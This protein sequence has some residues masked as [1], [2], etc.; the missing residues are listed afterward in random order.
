MHVLAAMLEMSIQQ[1]MQMRQGCK[2]S[3][4]HRVHRKYKLVLMSVFAACSVCLRI[5]M[6]RSAARTRDLTVDQELCLLTHLDR[7]RSL[8]RQTVSIRQNCTG[9]QHAT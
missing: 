5:H 3:S 7:G 1:N 8:C 9:I 2:F 4:K 6:A